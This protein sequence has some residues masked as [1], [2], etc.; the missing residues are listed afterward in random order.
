MNTIC[1]SNSI[2]PTELYQKI[3][4][5]PV[6]QQRIDRSCNDATMY[7]KETKRCLL[8]MLNKHEMFTKEIRKIMEDEDNMWLR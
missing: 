2:S 6:D 5:Y 1:L 8:D 3:L 7:R 4:G